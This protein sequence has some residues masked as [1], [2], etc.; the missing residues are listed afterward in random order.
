M[1]VATGEKL[2]Y[3]F[4]EGSR[5]MRELLGG[6]GANVAEMTRVLGADKVP[7]GFTITTEACVAYMKERGVP[8]GAPGA[9]RRG[10]GASRGAG[11]EAAR[12]QRRPAARVGPLG[13]ARVHAGDARHGPQPGHERR[14]GRGPRR[15]RRSNERF[16]WDSYRRFVQMFGNVCRGIKGDAIE[17]VIKSRKKDAGVEEDTDLDV[18]AL[19][20]PHRRPQEALQRRDRR[21][22]PAGP[23]RPARSGHPGRLRLLDGRQGRR[24]P[25]HQPHPRRVGHRGERAADG[26][27]QQGRQLVQR[28]RL[29]PRRGDGR[30]HAVRRLPAER[31]G[32]GRRLGRAHAARPARD[33][34]RDARG[35]RGADG[36]P[37]RAREALRRHA[38]HGVH[39]GGGQPLHAPDPQ[40]QAPGPGRGALRRGRGGRGAAGPRGGDHDDRRR[41]RSTRCCTRASRPTPSS[42]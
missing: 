15:R 9:D 41:T 39:R 38:G 12:R 11:G 33:E 7:A 21:G 30:A 10:A 35:P 27:R 19:Q 26:V 22:L 16:A 40:R 3:E 4:S 8:G 6:K 32:R 29:Q 13:R 42:T 37:H 1:A 18:D 25:A 2:V 20:G 24:V 36:H 5:D 23:A 17:D 31:A 14:L 28:G 34:G